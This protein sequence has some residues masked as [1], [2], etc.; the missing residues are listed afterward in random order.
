MINPLSEQLHWRNGSAL[1]HLGKVEVVNEDDAL[2]P[3][4]GSVHTLPPP[5]QL[6][7]DHVYETDELD[8]KHGLDNI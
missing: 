8:D 7:H 4:G 1:V 6:R 3:H 5:V 2:L